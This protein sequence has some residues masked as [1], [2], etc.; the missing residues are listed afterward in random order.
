MIE[1]AHEN[2]CPWSEGTCAGAAKGGHLHVLKYAHENGCPW[3]RMTCNYAAAGGHLQVLRYARENGCPW[4]EQTCEY[5]A[6]DGHLHVLTWLHENGCPWNAFTCEA[7]VMKAKCTGG[8]HF[9]CLKYA[10]ENGCPWNLPHLI[11][12]AQSDVV[13]NFLLDRFGMSDEYGEVMMEQG[14]LGDIFFIGDNTE[15]GDEHDDAIGE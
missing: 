2:G 11:S 4:S 3:D 10:R 7:A 1:Y 13:R 14:G 12:I 15:M 6:I 5:A 8:K 9:K